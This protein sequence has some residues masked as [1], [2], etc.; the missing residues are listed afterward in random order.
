MIDSI[1]IDNFRLFKEFVIHRFGRVN[2]IVGKNNTGKSCLLEAIR[3]YGTNASPNVLIDLIR[4]RGQDWEMNL[5][6]HSEQLIPEM[7][8]PLRHLFYGYRFPEIG[9]DSIEIGSVDNVEDRFKLHLRVYHYLETEEQRIFTRIED[10]DLKKDAFIDSD[11]EL[12]LEIE[13]GNKVQKFRLNLDP[14]IHLKAAYYGAFP[15]GKTR[16]NIQTVPTKHLD[17]EMVSALWDNINI[18]PNLRKEVFSGLKLIDEK[19]LEVVLVGREKGVNPILIY[20]DTDERIPLK[21][22]G[23]GM[24][25]LFHII[26]ALV[27]SRGGIVLIDEFENGLHYSVQSEIWNLVFQL[28]E[29]LDVQV[30]ATTHSWDC[31]SAFQKASREHQAEGM[32]IHLGPSIKSS[33]NGKIIPTLYD[34]DELQLAQQADLEVR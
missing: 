21:S 11:I 2:L 7:E 25:H 22:M 19:I 18:H 24:T 4:E 1:Y 34:P 30:F 5:Q 16:I 29:K 31:V 23:D 10:E 15:N 12:V 6:R 14:R 26:L 33:D 8:N 27:N 28:A 9:K 20:E 17:D 13:E 3:L 32:L